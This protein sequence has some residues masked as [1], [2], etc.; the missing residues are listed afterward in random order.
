MPTKNATT[1]YLVSYPAKDKASV[2]LEVVSGKLP[3][4]QKG[5]KRAVVNSVEELEGLDRETVMA[6]VNLGRKTPIT[7][8]SGDKVMYETAFRA[9]A[10]LAKGATPTPSSSKGTRAPSTIN[11]EPRAAS[12]IKQVRA[13]TKIA[14]LIDLLAKGAT[15]KKLG[16]ELSKTG[17]PVSIRGWIGYDLNKV[18][19]YG[20][21]GEFDAAKNDVFVT[22]V[23][24]KGLTA[25]KEH[26]VPGSSK[27]KA[28]K[29]T[30]PVPKAKKA[31]KTKKASKKVAAAEEAVAAEPEAA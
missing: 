27:P 13:G 29:K 2:T 26:L 10:R 15:L 11:Y 31:T 20:A 21:R 17:R 6:I 3:K 12:S 5:F 19:G 1:G 24:P 4:A 9:L 28:A 14:R 30:A 23:L 8:F 25:P 22:L 16:E 7:K 18:V